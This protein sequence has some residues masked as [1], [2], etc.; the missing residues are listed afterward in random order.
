M[1]QFG[2]PRALNDIKRSEICALVSAGCDIER[3]AKYVGC[4]PRTIRREALRNPE[5][6]DRLRKA[7]LSVELEPLQQ[8]RKK[9]NTH[10]RAAAWLLERTR[11]ERYAK[12][13]VMRLNKDQVMEIVEYFLDLVS[14]EID[15]PQTKRRVFNQVGATIRKSVHDSFNANHTRRDPGSRKTRNKQ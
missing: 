12:H 5:F 4:N 9:A 7:E 2:R 15:D 3:A 6:H 8:M 13:D 14:D 10:W 11:P 1:T